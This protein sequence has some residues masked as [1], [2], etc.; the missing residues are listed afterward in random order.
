MLLTHL[1]DC[2]G[3]IQALGSGSTPPGVC[4][5]LS[6][7]KTHL[8]P[9]LCWGTTCR[10]SRL[11]TTHFSSASLPTR[12][13]V[14]QKAAAASTVEIPPGHSLPLVM[15]KGKPAER[16]P[17]PAP[18]SPGRSANARASPEAPQSG[19]VPRRC[20]NRLL[21]VVLGHRQRF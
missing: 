19:P 16:R 15:G 17:S 20:Q 5:I 9:F 8:R 4:P 6:S 14:T 3:R 7:C 21:S 18:R 11:Q 2:S 12:T 10:M 1:S 13:C